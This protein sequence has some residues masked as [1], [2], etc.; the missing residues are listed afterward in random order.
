M[1]FLLQRYFFKYFLVQVGLV[2]FSK[3]LLK[4]QL[5]IS[6]DLVK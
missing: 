5:G 3:N 1:T 2:K 4:F 6:N